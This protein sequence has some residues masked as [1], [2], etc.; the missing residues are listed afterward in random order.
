MYYDKE[1]IKNEIEFSYWNFKDDYL[2]RSSIAYSKDIEINTKKMAFNRIIR[3]KYLNLEIFNDPIDEGFK[4]WK[5]CKLQNSGMGN[6][7]NCICGMRLHKECY[8]VKRQHPISEE[9]YFIRIGSLCVKQLDKHYGTTTDKDNLKKCKCGKR[10][11][12][13]DD[14]CK[15]CVII[16]D[17]N[18]RLTKAIN[19]L[20]NKIIKSPNNPFYR[21][22]KKQ[23]LEKGVLTDKQLDCIFK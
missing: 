19:I 9:N 3:V 13:E 4:E 15:K 22:L 21:S 5:L 7:L 2:Q 6:G 16:K 17:L 14:I 18:E 1:K 23:Y 10:K 11:K 8:Y 20:E 12:M